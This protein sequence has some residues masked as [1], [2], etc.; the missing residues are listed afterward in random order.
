[1][2]LP[3]FPLTLQHCQRRLQWLKT[4]SSLTTK[5]NII[6]GLLQ[7]DPQSTYVGHVSFLNNT[8]QFKCTCHAFIEEVDIL[9]LND[10]TSELLSLNVH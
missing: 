8:E 2:G 9:W 10:V 4:Q 3:V 6:T 1:M 7:S 5:G